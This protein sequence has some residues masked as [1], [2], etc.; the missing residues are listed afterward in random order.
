LLY[1][2]YLGGGN[3]FDDTA[4]GIALGSGGAVYLT[5]LATGSNFPTTPGAYD[6]AFS[7]T[8][9]SM[10]FVAEF[11]LGS[12]PVTLPTQT[13]LVSSANPAFTGNNLTFSA[14]VVAL[15]GT[16]IP[17]GNVIFNVDQTNVATV[18]LTSKGWA[19]YTTT[20]PL[21]MGGHAILASYQGNSTYAASGGNLTQAIVPLTPTITPAGGVYPAAQLVTIANATPSTILYYT[22]DGTTPTSSSSKYTA[23]ILVS[24]NETINAI[25]IFGSTASAVPS[26]TY[27]FISAPTV[28]AVPAS[29][30]STPDAT[31]N[32]LANTFG[33]TGSY[34]F[35]Y[36]TSSTA[37]A[38][39]TAT[40][41]LPSSALGSR[42]GLA[43]MPLSAK[44]TGLASKTTYYFQLVVTTPAGSSSGAVLSFSAN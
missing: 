22:L 35:K 43:P 11:N 16:G 36:G 6:T 32:A 17:A 44:L 14:S 31:L 4:F 27:T 3:S 37:L 7:S 40:T 23:P 5:G 25:A 30:I 12:G 34:Y 1:S 2:T 8:N 18:A 10:G 29:A 38:S 28:L 33:M 24:T 13:T 19:S 42:L 39:A 15:T 26:A 41:S 9:A 21:A 20:T